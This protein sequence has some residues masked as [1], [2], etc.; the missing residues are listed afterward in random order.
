M[1]ASE[2]LRSH[3]LVKVAV[4]S[5]KGGVGKTTVALNLACALAE[6]G[7]RTLLVDADP[8]GAIG[9]SL[10]GDTESAGGLFELVHEARALDQVAL[11]TRIEP[12]RIVAAG[13]I[14]PEKNSEWFVAAQEP[15]CLAPLFQQAGQ[16]GYDIVLA[17]TACGVHGPTLGVLRQSDHVLIPQQSEPLAGRALKHYLEVLAQV[18][19]EGAA[20]RIAGVVVT[21]LNYES[22]ESQ[23]IATELRE[24]IPYNLVFNATIPRDAAFLRASMKGLPVQLM[25]P[26]LAPVAKV[27]SYL[28]AEIEQRLDLAQAEPEFDNAPLLT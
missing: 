1:L 4:A 7:W 16:D 5:Q 17:D 19:K 22:E 3:C 26:S 14:P 28:A 25:D 11:R 6:R 9:L 24:S 13:Q 20:F 27:F 10:S 12:L 15:G 23:Q 18:L 2:H 8:Q 21:M